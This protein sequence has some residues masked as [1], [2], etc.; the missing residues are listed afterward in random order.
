MAHAEGPRGGGPGT[1]GRI[2]AVVLNYQTPASTRAAIASLAASGRP[3]DQIIV[4]DNNGTTVS[5]AAI[6][7]GLARDV[8]YLATP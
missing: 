2:A 6:L 1:P 5:R 3:P 8:C 4:V 7:D